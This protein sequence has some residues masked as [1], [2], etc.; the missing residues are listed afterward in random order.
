MLCNYLREFLL[1]FS[2]I[3]ATQLV[4]LFLQDVLMKDE[5]EE[6]DISEARQLAKKI[7][8]KVVKSKSLKIVI[9]IA[10]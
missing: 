3:Y 9:N 5:V 8:S 1:L 2:L 4:P 6:M 7:K 10:K